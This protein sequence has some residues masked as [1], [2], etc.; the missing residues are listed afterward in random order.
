MDKEKREKEE[1]DKMYEKYVKDG[2]EEMAKNKEDTIRLFGMHKDA[3]WIKILRLVEKFGDDVVIGQ[4]KKFVKKLKLLY[5]CAN[6][7][8]KGVYKEIPWPTIAGIIFALL[9]FLS[10]IDLIPD[11]IPGFG[12]IDDATVLL[13]VWEAVEEDLKKYAQWKGY[14]LSEYF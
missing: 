9:Y 7:Y 13:I 5:E 2:W 1:K 11:F 6:D 14:N 3:I 8:D 4:V 10:P 12:Y